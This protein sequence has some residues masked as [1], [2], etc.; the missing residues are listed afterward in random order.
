ML[1]TLQHLAISSEEKRKSPALANKP[2]ALAL[3][4]MKQ[5]QQ[6]QGKSGGAAL[7]LPPNVKVVSKRVG[8]IDR[9]REVGR[10]K[11]IEKELQYR[12]LPVTGK[13]K[14]PRSSLP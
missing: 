14:A 3:L 8:M 10:W 1:S 4:R 11:L 13:D 9:E 12:G 7:S 6:Q 5:Q 2:T